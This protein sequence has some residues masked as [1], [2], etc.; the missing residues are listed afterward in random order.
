MPAP[1]DFT[2][3]PGGLAGTSI[4]SELIGQLWCLFRLSPSRRLVIIGS[5]WERGQIVTP[6]V[7]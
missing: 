2:E 4:R 1:G 5:I 6:L 3:K 7:K